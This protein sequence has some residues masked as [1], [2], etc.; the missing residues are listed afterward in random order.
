MHDLII[1]ITSAVNTRTLYP[2]NHP[3]VVQAVEDT[4]AAVES[5]A[6]ARNSDS[7]T[8]LIVGDDLV[9]EQDVLRKTTLSHMQFI[10]VL[11]RRGVER[12]TLAVGIDV[13][14]VN[15]LV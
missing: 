6:G 13:A 9:A 3:R 11:K 1:A 4:G 12:L 14:E 5:A 8:F 15:Q 2:A 7:I 10:D